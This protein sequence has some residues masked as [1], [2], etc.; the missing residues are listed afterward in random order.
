M[1]AKIQ[2]NK[3][4]DVKSTSKL[5]EE[6][7][8]LVLSGSEDLLNQLPH[9]NWIGATTPF[10]YLEQKINKES[11]R[12]YLM[13]S[14]FTDLIK[15][16][17]I[18]VFDETSLKNVST[19]GFENGFNFL[20]LPALRDIQFSFALNS[21]SY[22]KL[23][24]NP[25]IGLV[26]G[27]DLEE[28]TKGKLSKTFYGPSGESFTD[29]AVVL[30]AELP[31][32][33][34]ARLEIVNVFEPENDIFIEVEEDAFRVK[35]CLIDGKPTSLYEYIK[36]HNIDTSY[37]LVCDYAGATVNV[38][39]QYLDDEKKE[40]VFYAPLF[41]G[42]KYTTS[43]KFDSYSESFRNRIE[44]VLENEK[45]IVYNCNCILNYLYGELDKHDIGFSGATTF[46][47]VAYVLLN[48]TFTYLAID[49][50]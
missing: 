15:S 28:F 42:K 2:E 48:Q 20:V 5:I 7:K 45:N 31:P 36:E 30:H 46:G 44:S 41:K 14:D 8:V 19:S 43:K 39:F 37:P 40:V 49:E 29:N 18:S 34:V 12:G 27:V 33:K 4:M 24:E 6:G 21:S 9:G 17:S 16:F 50:Q 47:E 26:A 1:K 38:S 32:E 25:L 23:F 35:N 13:V 3:L 22:E 10:F 11:G